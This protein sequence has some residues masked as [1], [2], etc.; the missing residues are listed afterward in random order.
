MLYEITVEFNQ[1]FLEISG[2]KIRIGIRS[3]PIKG[4]ANLEVIKKLSKH[5][6]LPTNQI[7]IRR[8]HKS[9]TKIIEIN[10]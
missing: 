3:K 7:R 2:N 5:F 9:Q 8:G 10:H 4:K 6:R 1:D